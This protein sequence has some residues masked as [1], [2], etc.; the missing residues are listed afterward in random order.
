V[1][2]VP[3]DGLEDEAGVGLRRAGR[4]VG[5]EGGGGGRKVRSARWG[6]SG[7]LHASGARPAGP[8]ACAR[9]GAWPRRGTRLAPRVPGGAQP[10]PLLKSHSVLNQRCMLSA[11]S[12]LG[13]RSPGSGACS[14]GRAR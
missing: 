7:A 8:H 11:G 5:R 2:L 1:L 3:A 6:G 4:P 12:R 10:T 13:S 14:R 9:H